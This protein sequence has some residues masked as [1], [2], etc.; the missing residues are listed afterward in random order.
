MGATL[1]DVA[2]VAGVDEE[3]V[4]KILTEDPKFK[5]DKEIQ[6]RVFRTARALK[7]NFK[8]LRIGKNMLIRKQAVKELIKY[9]ENNPKWGR[10]EILNYLRNNVGLIERVQKRAM[11]DEFADKSSPS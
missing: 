2:K 5:P 4:R 8:K 6:D 11:P 7:Y 1:K 3:T 10:E 9:I